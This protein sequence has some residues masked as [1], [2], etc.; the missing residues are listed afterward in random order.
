[1]FAP[2]NCDDATILKNRYVALV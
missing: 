1:M 2:E